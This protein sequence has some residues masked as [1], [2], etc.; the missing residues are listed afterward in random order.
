MRLARQ[1]EEAAQ[2]QAHGAASTQL[3][4]ELHHISNA[5][6]GTIA[7][8]LKAAGHPTVTEILEA[9]VKNISLEDAIIPYIVEST[10]YKNGCET[11]LMVKTLKVFTTKI[12]ARLADFSAA[13]LGALHGGDAF[14]SVQKHVLKDTC[15]RFA[16]DAE[17]QLT[18]AEGPETIQKV[19]GKSQECHLK[20]ISLRQ[21][22]NGKSTGSNREFII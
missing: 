21:E 15:F 19:I 9:D 16:H 2:K 8:D 22:G 5:R 18:M 6:S 20:V 13:P 4:R 12:K 1:L 17:P 11:E 14:R 7:L 10:S 3:R